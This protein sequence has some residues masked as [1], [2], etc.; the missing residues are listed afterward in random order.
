VYLL[1]EKSSFY[2]S[3]RKQNRNG[4]W[5]RIKKNLVG[6]LVILFGEAMKEAAYSTVPSKGPF[7][8]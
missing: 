5:K 3:E 4:N 7:P 1:S 2:E 6:I 8:L